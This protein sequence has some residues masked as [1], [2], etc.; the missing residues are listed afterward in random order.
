MSHNTLILVFVHGFRGDHTSFQDFPTDL[1]LHLSLQ[2][3]GLHTFVYP[4]YK[5]KRPLEVARDDFLNWMATLPPGGVVLC[6][7]S[8]GG[9][10]TAEVAFAA[11]P[12]R[13]IGLV[14]FDV[15]YLGVH[16]RVIFSGLASLFKK[17]AEQSNQTINS[18]HKAPAFDHLSYLRAPDESPIAPAFTTPST[19]HPTS[20]A[21]TPTIATLATPSPTLS[22]PPSLH[23]STPIPPIRVTAPRVEQLFQTF[24]FGP[25]PQSMHNLLH[26]FNKHPGIGGLKDGIVQI[27]EFGGCLLNPQGL[28]ARYERM[29]RWGADPMAG[30]YGRGWVNLWTT[31]VPRSKLEEIA[32]PIASSPSS[33]RSRNLETD[34][35]DV[36][37]YLQVSACTESASSAQVSATPSELSLDASSIQS[38]LFQVT[39][40]DISPSTTITSLESIQLKSSRRS[41]IN[42]ALEELRERLSVETLSKTERAKF[43][44]QESVL[45]TEQKALD[46]ELDTMHRE[47]KR[48]GKEAEKQAKKA[49]KSRRMFLKAATKRVREAERE[50]SSRHFIVLPRRGTDQQWVRV[51]VIGAD[52][53]IAAHCGLF[54][55]EE[56]RG[57][58]Q[59]IKDVGD[60]V[61]S[62]WDGEGGLRHSKQPFHGERI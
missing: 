12:G 61:R 62:F 10:L 52:D 31:P 18:E 49:D 38:S 40:C 5:T 58:N 51:P 29:Q 35:I 20:T 17:K 24:G 41:D 1:H 36:P 15:P 21:H 7:H 25:I 23:L 53:E 33:Q 46:K 32:E 22:H 48:R 13:V 39:S 8:M 56:N 47:E 11:P 44:S 60:I 4:T 27:F 28:I 34:K 55:R 45:K 59:L 57:Y 6:G 2:I 3:P 42:V 50:D 26:F 37:S 54:F 19:T 16:P 43:R 14:S 9:L 30:P